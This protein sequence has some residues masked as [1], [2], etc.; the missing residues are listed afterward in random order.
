MTVLDGPPTPPIKAFTCYPEDIKCAP[1]DCGPLSVAGEQHAESATAVPC[2]PEI[3]T[4]NPNCSPWSRTL[5]P[6]PQPC[7][8]K[9]ECDPGD[10]WSCAPMAKPESAALADPC[11][12]D[13]TS[14]SPTWCTPLDKRSASVT[15]QFLWLDMTR[16]CQLACEHCYNESGP[17]GTH[18]TMTRD[19]WFNVLDQAIRTG[20]QAV[21]LIGGEVTMHPD[22][23]AV[24]DHALTIGLKVE[25]FSNLVHIK[26][27]WWDQLQ[28]PGASLAT[29]YYSDDAAEHNAITGRDSHRKTRANIEKATGLGIPLRTGVI[30]TR[31]GQRVEQAQAELVTLGVTRIG[32]D[33]LRAFGRGQGEHAAC[34]VTELCGRCG[35]GRAAIGPDG[36]VTPCIMS[37]WLTAGNARD[38][39]LADIL[40]GDGMALATATIL[41]QSYYAASSDP[42]DP[43]GTCEPDEPCT[44]GY[45]GSGCSPRR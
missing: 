24:L 39:P 37:G 7:V 34:D 41:R 13:F 8:P 11:T 45:G 42:C 1:T 18:G 29:S 10:I 14:C 27:E 3:C 17:D 38:Q 28:R 21:Q 6:Q 36:T 22:F 2:I 23:L 43:A 40:S 12:P 31:P 20:V 16:K 26:D 32:T 5:G 19:D 35:D 30:A 33:R 15:A 9:M 4:P 25:V 44:P